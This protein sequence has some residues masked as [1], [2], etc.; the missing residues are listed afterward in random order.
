MIRTYKYR[1]Y[2]NRSQ[3]ALL[4]ETLETHRRLYNEA[5][6]GRM[7]CWDSAG[8]DL[9]Y[10]DQTNWL[11]HRRKSNDHY[12]KVN[13]TS[14]RQTLNRLDESY[15]KFFRRGGIPKIQISRSIQVVQ[16]FI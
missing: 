3:E 12:K 10:F 7:L 5:L 16:V 11:K 9:S 6:D 14:L 15:K 2:P 4:S 1:L 13:V 8:V